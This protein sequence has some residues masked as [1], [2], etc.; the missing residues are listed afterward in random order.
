MVINKYGH[1]VGH[2]ITN[3]KIIVELQFLS[4]WLLVFNLEL[5]WN[6]HEEEH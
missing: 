2:Q 6:K 1:E 3:L 4:F 5:S